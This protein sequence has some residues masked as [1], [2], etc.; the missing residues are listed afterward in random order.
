MLIHFHP[1]LVKTSSYNTSLMEF[2][3]Y[4]SP[5]LLGSDMFFYGW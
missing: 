5:G 2:F 1:V 3:L 4:V